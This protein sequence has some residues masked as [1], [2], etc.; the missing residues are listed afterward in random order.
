MATVKP[1][2]VLGAGGSGYW[3]LSLLKRQLYINYGIDV[4][5]SKD[6]KFLLLD[7]LSVDK[8]E[9]EY[10]EHIKSIGEKFS[11]KRREYLHLGETQ[12]GFF[13]WANQEQNYRD[14]LYS[15]FRRQL[16]IENYPVEANWKLNEGAAQMRQF[17]RM[18]FL[19]NKS[20]IKQAISSLLD[21]LK[22]S[23][24]DA[25]IP[26]WLFGSFAGGTGAGML[27]D[28]AMLTKLIAD[29]RNCAIRNIGGI[30]LPGVYKD[31]MKTS[32]AQG[33]AAFRELSRFLSGNEEKHRANI[34]NRNCAHYV[35]F[36]EKDRYYDNRFIFDNIVY[37][38]QECKNDD[39]RK[40]YFNKITD[41]LTIFFDYSG[42]KTFFDEIINHKENRVTSIS[43]YK[44]F[45]PINLYTQLFTATYLQQEIDKLFPN[46]ELST[47]QLPRE[48]RQN[49]I[50]RDINNF[51]NNLAPYFLELS[52]LTDDDNKAREYA[53]QYVI[54]Q[55]RMI[56][57][58]LFGFSTP[59]KYFGQEANSPNYRVKLQQLY[60]NIF[61]NV[62]IP[63]GQDI[64]QHVDMRKR[65]EPDYTLNTYLADFKTS[66]DKS[67]Q[68]YENIFK[69]EN[70]DRVEIKNRI[71]A[72][73]KRKLKRYISTQFKDSGV[74]DIYYFLKRT[75]AILE[76]TPGSTGGI[77]AILQS[78]FKKELNTLRATMDS[79]LNRL[80]GEFSKIHLEK[81][82]VRFGMFKRTVQNY[83]AAINL[84]NNYVDQRKRHLLFF[85]SDNL[86]N[87]L[88]E[89]HEEFS[90]Y[91]KN[92][93]LKSLVDKNSQ[94][95][96]DRNS[97][98]SN[99]MNQ[100][101]D[102]RSVMKGGVGNAS[103]IGV[104]GDNDE[105]ER[106]ETYLSERIFAEKPFSDLN[107]AFNENEENFQ[108]VYIDSDNKTWN[109][110]QPL[111]TGDGQKI[112]LWNKITGDI[113]KNLVDTR[114]P[115][116]EGIMHYLNWARQQFDDD[117][118][119][120]RELEKKL[121]HADTFIPVIGDVNKS[122]RLIYGDKQAGLHNLEDFLAA[123][124]TKLG[125]EVGAPVSDPEDSNTTLEFGDKNSLIF[126]A[127]S[128]EIP[129]NSIQVLKNIKDE[130][131]RQITNTG[132]TD[133]RAY[134]YHN[135]R[136][137][138]KIWEIEQALPDFKSQNIKTLTH[139]S[140]YWV[141]ED[142]ELVKLFVHC[143]AVGLI[144]QETSS[145]ENTYWVCGP[146]DKDFENHPGDVYL[147]SREDRNADLFTALVSFAVTRRQPG[148]ID[149]ID[150]DKI[151]RILIGTLNREKNN[152]AITFTFLKEKYVEEEE[153]IKDY[154][155]EVGID[156]YSGHMQL[157]LARI[158]WFYL[159]E[160]NKLN[161]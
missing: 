142:D 78:I 44:I 112:N 49:E 85:Q 80:S 129:P 149:N 119:F 6:I 55:P 107:V 1:S 145:L 56:F 43:T 99:L 65:N 150:F 18:S 155:K 146:R 128:N 51:L 130:Y 157:F 11:I 97:I 37:F 96:I 53:R 23:A 76:G 95:S 141:L 31:T 135:Y 98:K 38:D 57:D 140:F 27:L 153:W 45:V 125:H 83:E 158:F 106:Y 88:L 82:E 59:E 63:A 14:P 25:T 8:F 52:D 138:W 110:S 4:D 40:N 48:D 66:V 41:G 69:R 160:E 68:T 61:D 137:E 156:D 144:R 161:K 101:I 118:R 143:T 34:D 42:A 109:D 47:I 154:N 26:V 111:D 3:I 2:L 60:K 151:R 71:L 122:Y 136:C 10:K 72:I 103:S 127:Y 121:L 19:F 50:Q 134:A 46:S 73:F 152:H 133:W 86:V 70:D 90:Q 116:Y 87:L 147:L 113:Y 67:Y 159:K 22:Q 108:V 84:M 15:W 91:I 21:E 32:D 16:F 7:T 58:D 74:S 9:T 117:E 100:V 105:I 20:R 94:I 89:I 120:A 5:A 79:D 102:I 81:E 148:R 126:F 24:H 131:K 39:D 77:R 124:K 75:V 29:Q 132:T 54:R 114:L 62:K 13:S 33:Y 35:A 123:T 139:G 92:R 12:G 115:R 36:D 28:V 93:I 17:G 64:Q 30:V 104:I